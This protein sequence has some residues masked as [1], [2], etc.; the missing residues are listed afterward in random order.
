MIVGDPARF[1]IESAI[2]RAYQ[3]L[4]FRALGYFRIHVG[5]KAYGR[6][7]PE[8][9]LLACSFDTVGRRLADRGDH[10]AP[11]SGESDAGKIA[12]AFLNVIYADR[13]DASY[14]GLSSVEFAAYFSGSSN[15]LKWAPDGDE[16]FDDGSFVLQFDVGNRVRLI[17]FRYGSDHHHDAA[18]LSDMWILEEMFYDTLLE[19][20]GAFQNEWRTSPKCTE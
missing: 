13:Q 16:A 17:A 18:T 6:C 10:T 3:R 15:N 20:H 5:G 19:W 14:F 11:F 7:E 4:S 9:T 8:A 12:D 2:T 1:A